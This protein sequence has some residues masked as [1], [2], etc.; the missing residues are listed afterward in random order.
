MLADVGHCLHDEHKQI[1]KKKKGRRESDPIR[2][3][4]STFGVW[5]PTKHLISNPQALT[6]KKEIG[7]KCVCVI[8]RKGVRIR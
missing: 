8:F 6:N 4:F 7:N 1:D 5:N 3:P 2:V